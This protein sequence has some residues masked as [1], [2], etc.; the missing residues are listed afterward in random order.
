VFGTVWS[1]SRDFYD[2]I[3]EALIDNDYN[4]MM[5][6]RRLEENDA[7]EQAIQDLG[8]VLEPA[9][10]RTAPTPTKRMKRHHPT[11]HLQGICMVC[12]KNTTHVCRECQQFHQQPNHKQFWI[13]NKPGKHCM[14]AHILDL[15]PRLAD[16]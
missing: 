12:K 2:S 11:H 9:K 3:A 16:C 6:Q 5:L 10:Q 13:C 1:E 7:L 4:R 14:G 8:G 15:H